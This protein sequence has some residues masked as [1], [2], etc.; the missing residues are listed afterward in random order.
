M[1]ISTMSFNYYRFEPSPYGAKSKSIPKS[2]G[3]RQNRIVS[4]TVFTE[5]GQCQATFSEYTGSADMKWYTGICDFETGSL[6]D[7]REEADHIEEVPEGVYQS[8]R[9]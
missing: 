4:K 7:V 1:D 5:D 8:A 3:S 2:K 9:T 6:V